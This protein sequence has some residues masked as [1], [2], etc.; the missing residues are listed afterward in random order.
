MNF[1]T[2]EKI[3]DVINQMQLAELNRSAPRALL[4]DWF[5]GKPPWTEDEA[6]TNHILV[7]FNDKQGSVLLHNARAQ[8]EIAFL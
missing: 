7:N 1:S 4:N 5:N 2:A 6:K 3:N 8:Y